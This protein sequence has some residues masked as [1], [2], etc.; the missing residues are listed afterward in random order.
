MKA[1]IYEE[2]GPPSVLQ[3]A[4]VERPSPKNTELLIRVRAVEVTKAD[5]ELRSFVF[6]VKWFRWPLR[7]VMGVRKPK[8]KILGAYFSGEV[9]DLGKEVSKFKIGDQL[10]GVTGFTFGAYGE[11]LCVAETATLAHKAP[12][13]SFEDAAALSLGGLNGL[14]FMRKAG[15]EPGHKVLINGA[16]GSIG[17]FAVQIA[18]LMGAEVTAVDHPR[19]EDMLRS[20][21]ADHF[22]DYTKENFA[23]TGE[24]FDAILDMIVKNSYADNVETLKPGGKYLLGNPRVSDMFRTFL[25]NRFTNK[26]ASF[27]FAG[28][29]VE[30]LEALSAMI[31]EGKIKSVVDH[32]FS[33]E[34]AALA[35]EM[36]ATEKRVGSIVMRLA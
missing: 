18:K 31:T 10:V 5:C 13:Q 36:V 7:L 4:E 3:M 6:P 17:M 35:H 19:K 2:Y 26:S 16:G 11:F 27:A 9:V 30:E 21:G 1:V 23:K 25:T 34:E 28:E 22:I 29:K 12:E 32:V 14:H 8:N 15:I 24:K 20:I 33:M